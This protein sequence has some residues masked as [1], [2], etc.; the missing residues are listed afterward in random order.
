M[1]DR[2]R[3]KKSVLALDFISAQI[4]QFTAGDCTHQYR[5]QPLSGGQITFTVN[6]ETQST[7]FY[8]EFKGFAE[9][10]F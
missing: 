9:V 8:E 6:H 7:H 10:A 1:V 4:G 2:V 3:M 5:W